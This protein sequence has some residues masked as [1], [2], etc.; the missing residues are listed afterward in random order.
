M[1][2][3]LSSGHVTDIIIII[4]RYRHV[5]PKGAVRQYYAILATVW[6][7]VFYTVL[8]A[9]TDGCREVA[10]LMSMSRALLVLMADEWS[11]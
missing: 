11:G 1:A 3:G 8:Y 7:L 5:T 10:S 2:Y 9:E 4:D 6:L